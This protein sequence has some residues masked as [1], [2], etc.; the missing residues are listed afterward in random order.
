[1]KRKFIHKVIFKIYIGA[2][3]GLFTSGLIMVLISL[4]NG[5]FHDVSFGMMG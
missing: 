4:F 1:M 3:I 2:M 5:G